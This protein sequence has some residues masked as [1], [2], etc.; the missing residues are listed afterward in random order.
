MAK[1]DC[2][3]VQSGIWAEPSSYAPAAP[4]ALRTPSPEPFFLKP[5]ALQTAKPN[6]QD[7]QIEAT[8]TGIAGVPYVGSEL[9]WLRLVV[10]SAPS[11]RVARAEEA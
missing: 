9:V 10:P 3:S 7:R 1:C 2:R 8:E 6:A 5:T 4:V 11:R